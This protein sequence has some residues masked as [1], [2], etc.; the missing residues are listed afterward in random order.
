MFSRAEKSILSRFTVGA[1]ARTLYLAID[2]SLVIKWQGRTTDLAQ[3]PLETDINA[4][5]DA[6]TRSPGSWEAQSHPRITELNSEWNRFRNI[7]LYRVLARSDGPS[8][9]V[10]TNHCG[11]FFWAIFAY[12]CR[13]RLLSPRFAQFHSSRIAEFFSWSSFRVFLLTGLSLVRL[14]VALGW[15]YVPGL[16]HVIWMGF[17]CMREGSL[18]GFTLKMTTVL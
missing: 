4:V 8:A 2:P 11:P 6:Y 15:K 9:P 1:L 3:L 12:P 14:W 5:S 18:C 13:L 16:G 17:E 7:A 10:L